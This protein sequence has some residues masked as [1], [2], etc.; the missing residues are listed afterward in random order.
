MY[1]STIKKSAS[2]VKTVAKLLRGLIQ[3][4]V[5]A[6]AKPRVASFLPSLIQWRNRKG[7]SECNILLDC[8]LLAWRPW[9]DF[10]VANIHHWGH[11]VISLSP[12]RISF[13]HNVSAPQIIAHT[14]H[15]QRDNQGNA[16]SLPGWF[17]EV[18][19]CAVWSFGRRRYPCVH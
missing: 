15:Q 7:I 2:A 1:N 3:A 11:C 4:L 13:L 5:K 10:A 8:D 6:E 14:A 17:N 19:V 9:I 12:K 16:V 18:H